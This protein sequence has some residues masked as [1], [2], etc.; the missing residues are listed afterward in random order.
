M[1]W[2]G[3]PDRDSG[4]SHFHLANVFALPRFRHRAG[5]L[6]ARARAAGMST[7]LDA[8]WDAR[9]EWATIIDPAL[10][11]TG[12]LFV[13][14]DEAERLSGRAGVDNSSAYFLERGVRAV[15][16][17][18]GAE[19]CAVRSDG[20]T[21]LIPGFPV[22]AVDTTGAGDCFAGGFLAALERG[23]CVADAGRFANAVGALSVQKLGA[24]GGVR[25]LEQ[26]VEWMRAQD[27]SAESVSKS[28]VPSSLT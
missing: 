16:T 3:F 21:L 12:V 20:D 13:N 11:H 19:G 18:L 4:C 28:Q 6:I 27:Y 8:G 24:I 15:V 23:M 2:R 25:S 14:R 26:T 7:S 1:R 9:R 22:S 17:K 5:E 10:A